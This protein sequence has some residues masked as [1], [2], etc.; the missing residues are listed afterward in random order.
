MPEGKRETLPEVTRMP[1]TPDR[2]DLQPLHDEGQFIGMC[3]MEH[4]NDSSQKICPIMSQ[5]NSYFVQKNKGHEYHL[6]EGIHKIEEFTIC[7][8]ENC[9]AWIPDD[10]KCTNDNCAVEDSELCHPEKCPHMSVVKKGYCVL[11]F[12]WGRS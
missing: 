7:Q 2:Y 9:Q 5:P 8:G 10:R 3:M 6:R 1:T 11:I 12:P 4:I